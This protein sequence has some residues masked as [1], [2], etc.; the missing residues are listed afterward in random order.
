MSQKVSALRISDLPFVNNEVKFGR[1]KGG[2]VILFH[3][4]SVFPNENEG[5][6]Q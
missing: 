5:K 1:L 3:R 2:G 6:L 4:A